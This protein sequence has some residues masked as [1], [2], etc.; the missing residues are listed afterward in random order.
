[1]PYIFEDYA[2]IEDTASAIYKLYSMDKKEIEALG[3]KARKYVESE[4]SLQ[5]TIDQWHDSLKNLIDN[6]RK[7]ERV[8]ERY[9]I[10]EL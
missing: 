2:S 10:L 5:T 3:N 7:G 9:D 1:M 4:F 6:W 8:V